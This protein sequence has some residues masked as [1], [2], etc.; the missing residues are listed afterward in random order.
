MN[1]RKEIRNVIREQIKTDWKERQK[2]RQKIWG[3]IEY[4][5]SG[6]YNELA[7]YEFSN[8]Q[9]IKQARDYIRNEKKYQEFLKCC[10]EEKPWE[11]IKEQTETW[12]RASFGGGLIYFTASSNSHAYSKASKWGK[13]VGLGNPGAIKKAERPHALEQPGAFKH[14]EELDIFVEQ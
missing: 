4:F 11:T 5:A 13:K 6:N 9:L 2:K 8:D 12:W 3:C 1:L 10:E 14:D 7:D